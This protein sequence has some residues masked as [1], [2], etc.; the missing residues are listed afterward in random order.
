MPQKGRKRTSNNC[1]PS[2]LDCEVPQGQCEECIRA[3]PEEQMVMNPQK[4]NSWNG[5][6]RIPQGWLDWQRL[7]RLGR[8][9]RRL[10]SD[11]NTRNLVGPSILTRA[12]STST[13]PH[14]LNLWLPGDG[15]PCSVPDSFR[16]RGTLIPT[17]L[18][19]HGKTDSPCCLAAL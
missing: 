1:R 16:L 4:S 6:L 3:L 10:S 14:L 9:H 12:E 2:Q 13:S 17:E 8:L 5:H 18:G 11:G 19:E 7:G 15:S